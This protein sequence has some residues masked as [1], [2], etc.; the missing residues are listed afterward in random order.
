MGGGQSRELFRR[1]NLYRREMSRSRRSTHR[2]P[3]EREKLPRVLIVTEG[4]VT[5]VLYFKDLCADYSLGSVEV[6]GS[7]DPQPRAVVRYGLE[8]FGDGD[9]YDRLYCVF[10]RDR[11]EGF[12]T[13]IRELREVHNE[14]PRVFWTFSI[15]CF[16]YWIL[17][18]YEHTATRYAH[19]RSPCSEVTRDVKKYLDR[20]DKNMDELYS[21]T[22]NRLA[23]AISHAERRWEEARDRDF[24]DGSPRTKIH[25]LV[26]YLQG[27]RRR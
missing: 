13:A 1:Q 4:S 22:K 26:K 20:Y 2:R 25:L 18:H 7:S 14:V 10:D 19:P 17:L 24:G 23:T 9:R 21:Q 5:E 12:D 27:I 11:R 6:D 16:E 15:P 3:G 8:K